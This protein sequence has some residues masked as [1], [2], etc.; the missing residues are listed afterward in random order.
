[1]CALR[2]TSA[3]AAGGGRVRGRKGAEELIGDIGEDG[4]AAG[5]DFVFQA[6]EEIVESNVLQLQKKGS[7]NARKAAHNPGAESGEP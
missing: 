1:M 5:R 4:G 3:L 6:G 2:R 7:P